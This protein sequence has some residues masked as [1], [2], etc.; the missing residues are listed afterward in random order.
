MDDVSKYVF[1]NYSHLLSAREGL[2]WKNCMISAKDEAYEKPAHTRSLSHDPKVLELLSRGPEYF[3]ITTRN[4]VLKEHKDEIF[5]NHCPNCGALA[6]TP[7]A[8]ICPRCA[9]NWRHASQNPI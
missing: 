6:R 7:K 2:A 5:L 8:K 4:R 9:F 1:H 3:F